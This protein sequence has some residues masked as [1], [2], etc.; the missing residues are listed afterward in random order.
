MNT[1][2]VPPDPQILQYILG[3][4]K[5]EVANCE[6]ISQAL[7]FE[8]QLNAWIDELD[9]KEKEEVSEE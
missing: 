6:T 8:E 2:V 7:Q 4:K 3:V 5:V 9:R 1:R